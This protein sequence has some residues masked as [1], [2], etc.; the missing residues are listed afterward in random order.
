MILKFGKFKGKDFY[1]TPI[2]YQNWL[3][4]QP[5]FEKPRHLTQSDRLWDVNSSP[6]E[7]LMY[8]IFE[9]EKREQEKEDCRLRICTCCPD[10]PCYGL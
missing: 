9:Q 2:S 1:D 3:L 4:K 7:K 5:W 8:S 10:S 6:E